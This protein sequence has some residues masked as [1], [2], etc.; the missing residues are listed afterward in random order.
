MADES[1]PHDSQQPLELTLDHAYESRHE[2]V[3]KL[4]YEHWEQRGRPV[5]SP[6]VDWFAAERAVYESLV[7]SGLITLDPDHARNMKEDIY[8]PNAH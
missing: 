7:E 1:R 3:T 4:A 2:L 5:G 8:R 6:D